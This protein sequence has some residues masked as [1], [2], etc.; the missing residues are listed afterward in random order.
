[1]LAYSDVPLIKKVTIEFDDW[2]LELGP[3]LMGI[4]AWRVQA[5]S[6]SYCSCFAFKL[7]ELESYKGKPIH[8]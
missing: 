2:P 1:M 5:F 3:N 8:I 7:E 4:E 6:R